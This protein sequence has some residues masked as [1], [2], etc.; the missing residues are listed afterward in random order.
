MENNSVTA[1]SHPNIAFIKYWGNKNDQ[2]RIPVN[3]S[4]SMNLDG[5]YT[6]TT[7]VFGTSLNQNILTINGINTTGPALERANNMINRINQMI[8][9]NYFAKIDSKNNFPIGSGIASSAS[10]FA[11][12]AMALSKA[13]GLSLNEKELSILART[14]SG[15]ASRSIPEGFVEWDAGK[16][17]ESSYAYS[18]APPE[19]WKIA[20]CIVI[21]SREHKSIGSTK[22]H[23]VANTSP[24]QGARIKDSKRRLNLCRKALLEKDFDAFANIVEL[25]SNIMHAVMMTS[26]PNLIYWDPTTINIMKEVQNWRN[27]GDEVCYTIDAGPNVHVICKQAIKEN[28]SSRLKEIPGVKE[29][30]VSTPGKKTRLKSESTTS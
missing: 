23:K 8:G 16:D 20:D 26:T 4:I 5:L 24:L 6:Q 17:H 10:A 19:H 25:D 28:I 27:Q 18:I 9:T 29:V 30:L 12:L 2:L 3:S 11:A 14:G 15:S 22:G 1:I 21:I 7:V 13:A